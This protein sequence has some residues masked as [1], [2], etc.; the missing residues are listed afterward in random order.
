MCLIWVLH[1]YVTRLIHMCDTT[2]RYEYTRFMCVAS[3]FYI[4]KNAFLCVTW[5]FICVTRL[6][7]TCDMT[8]LYVCDMTDSYVRHDWFICV[9]WCIRMRRHGFFI[10]ATRCHT[11]EYVISF[12]RLIHMC[13]TSSFVLMTCLIHTCNMNH[14]YVKHDSFVTWLVHTRDTVHAYVWHYTFICFAWL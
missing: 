9:T 8:H 14:S 4:C 6:I 11:F 5:L 10:C 1:V 13:V 7:H 3:L 2:L 12:T